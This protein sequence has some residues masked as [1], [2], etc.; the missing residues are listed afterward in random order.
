MNIYLTHRDGIRTF[1]LIRIG[2]TTA[3]LYHP[4]FTGKNHQHDVNLEDCYSVFKIAAEDMQAIYRAMQ[5]DDKETLA[6]YSLVY[7]A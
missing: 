1:K 4:A 5:E 2:D 6:Y 7:S 3:T